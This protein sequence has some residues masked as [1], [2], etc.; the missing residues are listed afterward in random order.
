ML[1]ALSEALQKQR[2][3]TG[4]GK[5]LGSNCPKSAVLERER[6]VKLLA[7][8]LWWQL[9]GAS[10]KEENGEQEGGQ[11]CPFITGLS[12]SSSSYGN[13][14]VCILRLEHSLPE[15]T[16]NSVTLSL[17]DRDGVFESP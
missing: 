7:L 11:T 16:S 9:L 6:A 15:I 4:G 1:R 3:R 8:S 17:A 2:D 5:A 13:R 12:V 14:R 10:H